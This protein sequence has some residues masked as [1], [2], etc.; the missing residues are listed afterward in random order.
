MHL[1]YRMRIGLCLL[2]WNELKGCQCDVPKLPR[3]CF[4]ELFAIDGGSTDGTIE[5]LASQGITAVQQPKRGYNNAYIA[6]FQRSSCDALV[7][8]HPKGSIDPESLREMAAAMRAGTQLVIASPNA[9]GSRNEEDGQLLKPRK[10]FV[11]GL[12]ALSALLW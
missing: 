1:R 4:D 5:Y 11:G 3:D 8:F 9:R 6:A 10:W 7:I 2:V 12:S